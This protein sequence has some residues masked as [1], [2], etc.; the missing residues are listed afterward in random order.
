[1]I[2]YYSFLIL[3]LGL[4]V[5]FDLKSRLVPNIIPGIGTLVGLI[6]AYYSFGF[7]DILFSISGVIFAT[8][9]GYLLW[10][11]NLIGGGDHKLLIMVAAFIW[12]PGILDTILYVAISGALIAYALAFYRSKRD[13]LNI[14]LVLRQTSI[15]YTT[16]ILL[17]T[18]IQ[19]IWK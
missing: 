8:L 12:F 19:I 7:P 17:G 6:I 9:F 10:Y 14:K 5:Y 1:M 15:P 11:L 4:A 13:D 16:A 18:L 2:Y 3:F